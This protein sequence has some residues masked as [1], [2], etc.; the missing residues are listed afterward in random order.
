MDN[1]IADLRPDMPAELAGRCVDSNSDILEMEMNSL[2]THSV[3]MYPLKFPSPC[4]GGQ[5]HCLWECMTKFVNENRGEG[6]ITKITIHNTARPGIYYAFVRTSFDC[7]EF[8]VNEL[9]GGRLPG[10]AD[11]MVIV[12]YAND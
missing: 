9:N 10:V 12:R 5:Q 6:A 4:P 7:A 8:L 11:E 3:W 1:Q 2:R